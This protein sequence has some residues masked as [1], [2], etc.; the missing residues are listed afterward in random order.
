MKTRVAARRKA[1]KRKVCNANI[2]RNRVS[3]CGLNCEDGPRPGPRPGPSHELE[4][5]EADLRLQNSTP[6]Q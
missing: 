4:I 5:A 1:K 2:S 3:S 6:E